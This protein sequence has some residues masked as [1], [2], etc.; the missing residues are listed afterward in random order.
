MRAV[1]VP[2]P[3]TAYPGIEL[4]QQQQRQKQYVI[5]DNREYN[6]KFSLLPNHGSFVIRQKQLSLWFVLPQGLHPRRSFNIAVN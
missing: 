3:D 4:Q 2:E 6:K 5:F 1:G